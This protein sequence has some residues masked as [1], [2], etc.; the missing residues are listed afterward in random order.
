MIFA[1]F[2]KKIATV[3]RK[4]I[5][6]LFLIHIL[7]SVIQILL[8][9]SHTFGCKIFC[10]HGK[11][12]L[13]VIQIFRVYNN[14]HKL[15]FIDN[16]NENGSYRL[17]PSYIGTSQTRMKSRFSHNS[18]NGHNIFLLDFFIRSGT[19]WAPQID[20]SKL[21]NNQ[22]LGGSLRAGLPFLG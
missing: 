8:G 9:K 3:C 15:F 5:P 7:H 18:I 11:G 6:F 19:I 20:S 17:L 10:L 4:C 22:I 13:Y 14:L 21:H 2:S 1:D 16:S 12:F